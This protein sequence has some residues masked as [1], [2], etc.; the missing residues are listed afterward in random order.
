MRVFFKKSLSIS[1]VT[2]WF[3]FSWQKVGNHYTSRRRLAEW[4]LCSLTVTWYNKSSLLGGEQTTQSDLERDEVWLR[5]VS[6]STVK[7]FL[8]HVTINLQ[9]VHFLVILDW[10][11]YYDSEDVTI[12]CPCR[13]CCSVSEDW[14]VIVHTSSATLI[15]SSSISMTTFLAS[16]WDGTVW[17]TVQIFSESISASVAPASQHLVSIPSISSTVLIL[18]G[19]EYSKWPSI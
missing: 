12:T 9:R 11:S 5:L 13:S 16:S 3:I 8:S 6:C 15:L 2:Y 14:W 4:A 17:L 1:K 18:S 7:R 19:F 10:H